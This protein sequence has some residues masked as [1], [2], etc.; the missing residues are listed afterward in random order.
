[1][2][3]NKTVYFNIKYNNRTETVDKFTQGID[4]PSNTKE[5]RAY[6]RKMLHEYHISGQNVYRS[7]RSC[8]E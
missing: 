1:M 4:A 5:F 2:K 7:Q 6:I 8:K 3:N